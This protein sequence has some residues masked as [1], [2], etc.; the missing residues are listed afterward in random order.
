VSSHYQRT[1]TSASANPHITTIALQRARR[2]VPCTRQRKLAPRTT[3]SPLSWGRTPERHSATSARSAPARRPSANPDNCRV[4]VEDDHD[5]KRSRVTTACP[6]TVPT[7][8]TNP[9]SPRVDRRT[10]SGQCVRRRR[11]GPVGLPQRSASWNDGWQL[12]SYPVLRPRVG[13]RRIPRVRACPARRAAA[14]GCSP[15]AGRRSPRARDQVQPVADAKESY[16]CG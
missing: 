5:L 4:R 12:A 14:G 13:Q 10:G 7:N 11:C 16:S 15:A 1:S 6:A 8:Y 2:K 9:P 3:R